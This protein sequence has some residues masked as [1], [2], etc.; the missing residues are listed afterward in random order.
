MPMSALPSAHIA[1]LVP[2]TLTTIAQSVEVS[3]PAARGHRRHL[4]SNNSRGTVAKHN[5]VAPVRSFW[6]R[7]VQASFVFHKI[8]DLVPKLSLTRI[9]FLCDSAQV[10]CESS[11]KISVK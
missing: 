1:E 11:F 2:R 9:A 5:R 4:T 10:R 8:I 3:F 7:R 6:I